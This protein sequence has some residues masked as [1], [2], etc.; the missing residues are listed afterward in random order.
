MK[1]LKMLC[2]IVIILCMA[3]I[4]CSNNSKIIG[5]W[6]GSVDRTQEKITFE[7]FKDK[8]CI[9]PDGSSAKWVILDGNRI[10]IDGSPQQT[11]VIM[12]EIKRGG[13]L[14][15]LDYFGYPA[16]LRKN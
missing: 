5:K 2:L 7:F 13:T 12:G 4:G 10:K 8:T 1:M 6:T 11:Y 15:T 14:L 9:Y 16:G 3:I